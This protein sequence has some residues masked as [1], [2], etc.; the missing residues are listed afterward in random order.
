MT[1]EDS[2]G[3][4]FYDYVPRRPGRQLA[5]QAD[6]LAAREDP[7]V[8]PSSCG[9]SRK[10]HPRVPRRSRS[11]WV[12]NI[13][14][15]RAAALDLHVRLQRV[16]STASARAT[17]CSARE[18]QTVANRV[19]TGKISIKRRMTKHETDFM[20]AHSPGDIKMTL[21][22]ANQFRP[23]PTRRASRTPSTRTSRSSGTARQ[24]ATEVHAL[25]D[26]G[27]QY[28]QLDAPR[29]SYYIDPS[30]VSTCRTR[31]AWTPRRRW[32]TRSRSTTR[33]STASPA[34]P[35]SSCIHP[36][37][38]TTAASGTPEGGYDPIAEKLF[39]QLDVD[40][41]AG[42]RDGALRSFEPLRFVPKGKT[43]VLGISSKVPDLEPVDVIV[44][45]INE[46]AK[47]VPWSS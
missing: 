28:I 25:A 32:T 30:G 18:G 20:K 9:S 17:R 47:Y 22:S 43:V 2:G 3:G 36:A 35:A 37:A 40:V 29:Y 44:E 39:N 13:L 12:Q 19:A 7:N 45:R 10:V 23:S 41:L 11:G 21:P 6:L 1:P 42:V 34:A 31:W 16:S 33:R 8:S 4:D 24:V 46:A 15:R 27:I 38:A 5:S 26:E 14:R